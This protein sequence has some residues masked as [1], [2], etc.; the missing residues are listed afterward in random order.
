MSLFLN[1]PGFPPCNAQTFG[2]YTKG[3]LKQK[4]AY[5]TA[6]LITAIKPD[7]TVV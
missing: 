3:F 4:V 1:T 2:T 7:T 5:I 6:Q